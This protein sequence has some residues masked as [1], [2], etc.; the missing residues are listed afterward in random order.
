MAT[1]LGLAEHK[2]GPVPNIEIKFLKQQ[3]ILWQKMIQKV[4]ECWGDLT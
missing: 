1:K 4:P 3:L 2:Y